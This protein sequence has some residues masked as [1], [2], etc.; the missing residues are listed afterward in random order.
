MTTLSSYLTI[1][2]DFAKWQS[3]TAQKPDYKAQTD[4]FRANIGK[5]QT[6]SDFVNDPRL[7]N[8]AMTAFGLGDMTYA[9]G[10]ISKVLKQ[11]VASSGALANTLNN[12]KIQAFARAFDFAGKGAA[13][14]ASASL[15]DGVVSKY[16]E[17]A[18]ESDRGQQNPGVQLALYF[19]QNA[20][21][22]SSFY[23]ILADKQLLHV[24]QVALGL[25]PMTSLEPIDTQVKLMSAKL[26][27]AD[28]SN[29]K[30]LQGFIARFA[31]MY[32]SANAGAA[33]GSASSDGIVAIDPALMLQLHA[34][35]IRL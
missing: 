31:A 18:L 6:A 15:V 23:G 26:N 28:F 13:A 7:F 35:S 32:D 25:S 22:V 9:K 10:L 1:S 34:G 14:T 11:G 19:A 30:K 29:P 5:A 16:A 24:V 2:K 8:Y 20:P 21:K 4:Y 27:V 12:P 33:Q 3:L 17:T